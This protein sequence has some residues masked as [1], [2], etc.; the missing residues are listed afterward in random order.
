MKTEQH[1]RKASIS[2]TLPSPMLSLGWIHSSTQ[3]CIQRADFLLHVLILLVYYLIIKSNGFIYKEFVFTDYIVHF[4]GTK[5]WFSIYFPSFHSVVLKP[6]WAAESQGDVWQS[7]GD[8]GICILNKY[9]IRWR[10]NTITWSVQSILH[11]LV[12]RL[13]V[14]H[15]EVDCCA[16]MGGG[17]WKHLYKPVIQVLI[18]KVLIVCCTEYKLIRSSNNHGYILSLY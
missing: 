13:S 17:R 12:M 3:P 6:Q 14:C 7:E 8:L 18:D 5:T 16:R 10:W 11:L 1:R 9:F 2:I 4:K 15:S